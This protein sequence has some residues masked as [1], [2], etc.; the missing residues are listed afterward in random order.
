M[1]TK[2]RIPFYRNPFLKET[3][4]QS[5]LCNRNLRLVR[6]HRLDRFMPIG[7][8]QVGDEDGRISSDQQTEQHDTYEITDSGTAENQLHHKYHQNRGCRQNRSAECLIDALFRFDCPV[9]ILLESEAGT[10]ILGKITDLSSS[11]F[12]A[13]FTSSLPQGSYTVFIRRDGNRKQIG[14]RN[15]LYVTIVSGVIPVEPDPGAII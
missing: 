1:K 7:D 11:S 3:D 5:N 13:V 10:M 8:D 14:N 2:K 6:F 15:Q 12:S 9:E 4:L